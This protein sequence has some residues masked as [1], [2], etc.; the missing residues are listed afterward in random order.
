MRAIRDGRP[1]YSGKYTRLYHEE[2][3]VIMSDTVAEIED[4]TPFISRV[5]WFC[6][7]GGTP[8]VLINGLG[9]GLVVKACLACPSVKR[10]EIVEIDEQLIELVG[11]YYK[12]DSRVS[13]YHGD[14]LEFGWP[15]HT[16]WDF[17][18]Y[19]IWDSVCSDNLVQMKRLH[20]RYGRRVNEYRGSWCHQECLDQRRCYGG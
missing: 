16:R 18:W 4:H 6:R 9:L 8:R 17:V 2:R 13:V 15:R 19:D 5:E 3:G 10:V 20:R 11:P 7:N 14:A 12:R 1:V